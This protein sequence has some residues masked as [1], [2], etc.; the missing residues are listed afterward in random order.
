M[1]RPLQAKLLRFLEDGTFSRVG[2]TE[3]L[4][5]DVRLIAATNRDIVQAIRDNQF[6]EDLFHRLNVV[7]FHP[8][9]PARTWP[10]CPAPG[11]P[12]PENIQRGDEQGDAAHRAPRRSRSC[13]RTIGPAMSASCATWWSARSFWR[14]VMNSIPQPPGFPP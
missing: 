4:G 10:G 7:Q 11:G 3:E 8:A 2:G 13:C 14:P 12:F 1:S 9:A 5:V 6:R